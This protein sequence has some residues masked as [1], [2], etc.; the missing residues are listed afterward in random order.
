M[1]AA[2]VAAM[3][4]LAA[5]AAVVTAEVAA[6]AARAAVV[7]AAADK[8]STIAFFPD[9][10]ANLTQRVRWGAFLKAVGPISLPITET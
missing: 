5:A 1:A 9:A 4:L 8:V 10:P 2:C 7:E 3:H 6:P